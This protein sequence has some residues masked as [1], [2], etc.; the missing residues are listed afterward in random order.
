METSPRFANL[1]GLTKKGVPA[2]Y[3]KFNPFQELHT[4]DKH[5]YIDIA[6]H[7]S[8]DTPSGREMSGTS[9]RQSLQGASPEQF[10][11]MMGWFDQEAYELL[12]NKLKESSAMA[13][14]AIGGASGTSG[15]FSGVVRRAGNSEEKEEELVTE[16]VNYLLGIMVG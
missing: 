5:G 13:M 11:T 6:P 12:R 14:G 3:K 16:V 8:L 2:Y 1:D 15:G 4:L 9:L 7:V 10:E